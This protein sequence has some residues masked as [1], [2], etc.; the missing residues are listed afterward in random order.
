[1]IKSK[2]IAAVL[3][4][5][6]MAAASAFAFSACGGGDNTDKTG[7]D[8]K[9]QESTTYSVT[10][11]YNYENAPTSTV[12]SVASGSTVAK[13]TDP[14]RDGYT[15][16]GWYTDT[17]LTGEFVFA[18][19]I[20]ADTT[21]YAGWTAVSADG[22]TATKYTFEAECVDLSNFKGAGYSGGATGLGAIQNDWDG[23]YNASGGR[24]VTFLYM[25]GDSTKLTFVINSDKEVD[26]AV[27]QIRVSGEYTSTL[28][29]TC[30]E[31][32][33][34]VNGEALQYDTINIRGIDS[35]NKTHK[36]FINKTIT[37][38]LHLKEGENTIELVTNNDKAI[39]GTMYATAPMVD[40]LY[41]TT[42]AVLT[43][44]PL[45]NEL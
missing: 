43:W 1:M 19:A 27:L 42:D 32:L 24:Y 4:G 31:Y 39:A 45:E 35:T 21:V 34:K 36:A 9:K 13:P 16:D 8:D 26:D 14:T 37:T 6:V 17:E 22:T 41:I 23:D 5:I 2:K 33:I 44:N 20:T 28:S 15:F 25:K 7:G 18:N 3:V 30:D 11:N 29:F 38:S 10:F 40:C 12:V